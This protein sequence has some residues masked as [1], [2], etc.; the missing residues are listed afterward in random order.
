MKTVYYSYPAGKPVLEKMCYALGFFDGVHI[1]HR[2]LILE[3]VKRAHMLG[4]SAAVFTFP[5]ESDGIKIGDK[6]LYSTRDKLYLLES[7]GIECT[8][9]AD[10]SSVA[11]LSPED[12]IKNVLIGELGCEFALSGEGFRFG[13]RASGDVAL[14][15]RGLCDAGYG[16]DVVL[17]VAHGDTPASSTRIREALANCDI[18][19]ANEMLSEPFFVRGVVEHGR[20]QGRVFG[21]PTVNIALPDGFLL[22]A[23]V[24]KTELDID[25]RAYTC[26]TN[27][28]TCPSFGERQKHTE[29]LIL[30]YSGDLY[31]RE[32]VLKFLE[33]IRDER[34]FP[35]A[36]E[37]KKQIDSDIR[38]IGYGRS[39]D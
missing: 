34:M 33:Y 27:V 10:F 38:R 9:V 30:G 31:E 29:T 17:D 16:S 22:P 32:L 35:S 28:G 18:G 21:I 19:L 25:G 5:S 24:Y 13:A 36:E 8:V 6:R 26:L 7:L 37:L 12:F 23:G 3:C 39:M 1:G 14:L 20:G 2:K 4:L 15:R 11:S